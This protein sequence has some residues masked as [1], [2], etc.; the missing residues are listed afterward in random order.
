MYGRSIKLYS[1]GDKKFKKSGKI[2]LPKYLDCSMK[3]K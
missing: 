3:L 1:G 2:P